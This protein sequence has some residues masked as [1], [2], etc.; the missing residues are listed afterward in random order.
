MNIIP[1]RKTKAAIQALRKAEDENKELRSLN[2][3]LLDDI[4]RATTAS[5]TYVGNAYK[6]YDAIIKAIADKYQAKADWGCQQVGSIIDV[7]AA[8]IIGEGVQVSP[9]DPADAESP[10]MDF[11]KAFFDYNDLDREMPQEFAKEAEMEGCFLGLLRWEKDPTFNDGGMVALRY[12]SRNETKYKVV[13]PDDDYSYYEKIEWNDSKRGPQ[14]L[15]TPGFVYA[16]F[17]GRVHLPNEPTPKIG[18]VLTEIEGLSKAL[19]DWREINRLFGAP[20]PD[21]EC[22]SAEQA[23]WMADNLEAVWRNLKIKKLIAHTGRFSYKSPTDNSGI[24]NEIITLAK[25]I[26]GA[27]GV[28]VHFLGLPDLMSNRSTAENLMELVS[29]ST[30]KERMVWIGTYQQIIRKAMEMR[31]KNSKLTPLNPSKVKV[32][33]PYISQAVWDRITSVF[34]PL[35]N[36]DGLS[37]ETMLQQIPGIDVTKEMEKIRT[38]K[39]ENAK[40]FADNAFGGGGK[41]DDED[42]ES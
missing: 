19:R 36:S 16:R 8:F 35:Y 11:A 39:D 40:R 1:G 20:T 42:E 23:Q 14:S 38:Q 28:P 37:L 17:G 34:M 31:N 4:D 32:T 3:L 18:K 33:I 22:D 10:E 29:A 7:R 9:V 13:T 6:T 12:M 25:I 41:D 2:A 27:T 24:E 30:S 5:S 21:I 26:S 15:E